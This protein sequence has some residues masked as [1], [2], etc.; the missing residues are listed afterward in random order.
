[1]SATGVN[2]MTVEQIGDALKTLSA[3]VTEIA[4]GQKKAYGRLDEVEKNVAAAVEVQSGSADTQASRDGIA[5]MM[6]AVLQAAR[7]DD[8]AKREA[9]IRQAMF[10]GDKD[11]EA[12]TLRDDKEKKEASQKVASMEAAIKQQGEV[13][14]IQQA[15]MAEPH[16][17]YLSAAYE[18][19]GASP[20]MVKA[21]KEAWASMTLPQLEA[22]VEGMRLFVNA[23]VP[24]TAN[25]SASVGGGGLP[26]AAPRGSGMANGSIQADMSVPLAQP[27]PGTQV[28]GAPTHP[29]VSPIGGGG[30]G[31]PFG[32]GNGAVGSQGQSTVGAGGGGGGAAADGSAPVSVIDL[33]RAVMSPIGRGV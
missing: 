8:P 30:F 31:N 9:A 10:H 16:L 20:D 33:H 6:S 26:S 23:A 7:E 21:K 32:G 15:K 2:L 19:V 28:P 29:P 11:K 24:P 5:S 4:E 14:K 27:V 25:M 22:E 12:G 13:I 17:D 3:S 18:S 1:M